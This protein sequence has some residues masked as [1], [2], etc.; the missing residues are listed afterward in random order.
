MYRSLIII[1]VVLCVLLI[2]GF[3]IY[4]Y[5]NGK[6]RS[7]E[8]IQTA[9][10]TQSTGAASV[11]YQN[12]KAAEFIGH[13]YVGQK[14]PNALYQGFLAVHFD[15]MDSILTRHSAVGRTNAKKYPGDKNTFI[16]FTSAFSENSTGASEHMAFN[17]GN[18]SD[19]FRIREIIESNKDSGN[20]IRV[21][22][23]YEFYRPFGDTVT[24]SNVRMLFGYDGDIGNSLGGCSDDSSGYFENDSSAI[25]YVFD[26]SLHFYSG[27]NLVNKGSNAVAGNYALLHHTVNLDGAGDEDLDTLLYRLMTQPVFDDTLVR[28][29][30]TVYWSIDLGT[31][32]PM[33]TIRD[34]VCFEL[35]NGSSKNALIEAAKGRRQRNFHSELSPAWHRTPGIKLYSNYPNPFNPSTT[36]RFDLPYDAKVSIKIYNVLGQEVRELVNKNYSAG[37]QTVVWDTKNERN[38][39]VASGIYIYRIVAESKANGT[40]FVR[41]DKMMFVK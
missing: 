8:K 23:V 2:T 20:V 38:A 15:E 1:S 35:V 11:Y 9:I 3:G 41:S 17:V 5:D 6:V 16:G 39:S 13:H 27:I 34:T 10:G 24:F 7:M 31:V 22:F 25:V 29:D 21:S 4:F 26:D 37:F 12:D 33:D 14:T 32:T 28:T 19:R 18:I 40:K 36:I 30:V